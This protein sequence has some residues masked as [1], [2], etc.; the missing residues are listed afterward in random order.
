MAS[1]V[2]IVDGVAAVGGWGSCGMAI[3]V[4]LDIVS[5]FGI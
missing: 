4:V 5:V 1:D 3:D 2:E